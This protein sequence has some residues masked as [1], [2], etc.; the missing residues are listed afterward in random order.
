MLLKPGFL[1]FGNIAG[2][3]FIEQQSF[4][5]VRMKTHGDNAKNCGERDPAKIKE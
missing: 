5:G 1:L 2:F 4:D 3:D